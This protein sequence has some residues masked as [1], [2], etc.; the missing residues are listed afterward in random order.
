MSKEE[1]R[2]SSKLTRG[3]IVL[4]PSLASNPE[5]S[6]ILE[7]WGV[8][9]VNSNQEFSD[10]TTD[11]QYKELARQKRR[12]YNKRPEVAEKKKAYFEREDV[13][14]R[15]KEYSRR[16]DVVQKKKDATKKRNFI[17][18]EL[19]KKDPTLYIE[20]ANKSS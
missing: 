3:V 2:K 13:K 1:Q 19:R 9:K 6:A 7:K 14:Q 15:R 11:T 4:P 5:V 18:A 17:V 10:L 12:E 8:F 16:P 20:L